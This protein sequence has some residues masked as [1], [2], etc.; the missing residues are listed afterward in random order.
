MTL[1]VAVGELRWFCLHVDDV[2][3]S[4]RT[5][6]SVRFLLI[7]AVGLFL[8]ICFCKSDVAQCN[9]TNYGDKDFAA[10][11]STQPSV[12]SDAANVRR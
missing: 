1:T 10:G 7:G 12:C 4:S 6:S 11:T 9:T 3:T 5:R 2:L 8:S